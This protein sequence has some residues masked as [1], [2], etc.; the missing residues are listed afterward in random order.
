VPWK[1]DSWLN[2]EIMWYATVDDRVLGVV[3]RDRIDNDFGWIAL[4]RDPDVFRGIDMKTSLPTAQAATEELHG[5]MR[6]LAS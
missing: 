2:E 4:M 1:G 3:V 5:L 6:E